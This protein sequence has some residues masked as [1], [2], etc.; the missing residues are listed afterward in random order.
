MT[1]GGLYIRLNRFYS[2]LILIILIVN[3]ASRYIIFISILLILLPLLILTER[4]I[5][6]AIH[7]LM[8]SS[9]YFTNTPNWIWIYAIILISASIIGFIILHK[10]KGA[11]DMTFP[12][13]Y[14][15]SLI[16]S[17]LI[18][19][20]CAALKC[21]VLLSGLISVKMM[22]RGFF[23]IMQ[24]LFIIIRAI[25]LIPLWMP[26]FA[27]CLIPD[28][29]VAP[30]NST[31]NASEFSVAPMN[32]TMI[33]GIHEI[34]SCQK[35]FPTLA[36][37]LAKSFLQLWLLFDFAFSIDD[38]AKN[39]RAFLRSITDEKEI[40]YDCVICTCPPE[41]PVAL[42]CNHIFCKKCIA[43]WMAENSTCPIC[44]TPTIELKLIEFYD[45]KM[46]MSVIFLGF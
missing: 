41:E 3:F 40:A 4:K 37:L 24:R 9:S 31:V 18:F 19:L 14:L 30:I 33:F 42:K 46:P 39:K 7:S 20:I 21:I 11:L 29:P 38:Y 34:M 36:Y 2:A 5:S 13:R 43:R 25:A 1:R 27:M 32:Q 28:Q 12:V 44:R 23:G 17:T 26:Y 16:L 22:K 45:G 35:N 15:F 10:L 8:Q 6:T